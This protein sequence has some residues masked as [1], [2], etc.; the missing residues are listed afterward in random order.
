MDTFENIDI[1]FMSGKK[2]VQEK[3]HRNLK[4]TCDAEVI[5]TDPN[6]RTRNATGDSNDIGD[7][8]IFSFGEGG[9][10]PVRGL[11]APLNILLCNRGEIAVPLGKVLQTR[12][13]SRRRCSPSP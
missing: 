3:R 1:F 12:I 4:S 2:P 11:S 10:P 7:L 9:A 13:V 5:E 6:A 8:S